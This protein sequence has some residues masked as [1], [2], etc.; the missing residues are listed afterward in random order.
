[1]HK[2]AI[3]AWILFRFSVAPFKAMVCACLCSHF[4]LLYPVIAAALKTD[5]TGAKH[6]CFVDVL[7]IHLW[8][9]Q[10]CTNHNN[11]LFGKLHVHLSTRQFHICS[12]KQMILQRLDQP[13]NAF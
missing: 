11:L 8:T 10:T 2:C 7:Q 3:S 9:L 1:M 5:N 13:C 6:A 12:Q 4:C